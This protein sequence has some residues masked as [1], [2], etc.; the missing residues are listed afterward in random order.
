MELLLTK[1]ADFLLDNLI[2]LGENKGID[3]LAERLSDKALENADDKIREYLISNLPEYEYEQIDRF[4]SKNSIYAHSQAIA[5][6][7]LMSAQTEHLVE[8]FYKN[9]P[10]LQSDRETITPLLNKAFVT[11]YQSVMGQLSTDCKV[12]YSQA[13]ESRIQE[14]AEHEALANRLDDIEKRL[15]QISTKLSYAEVIK[16]FN[17]IAQIIHSGDLSSGESLIELME[18]QIDNRENSYCTALKIFLNG[19][20]GSKDDVDALCIQFIRENP[21][22]S[23]TIRVVTFLLQMEQ[24]SAIKLIADSIIDKKL[25]AV[26]NE[27]ISA[28]LVKCIIDDS[29]R[30][31]QEYENEEYA[32][33]VFANNAKKSGNISD[34]M[35]VYSKIKEQ[36]PSFWVRWS[37]ESCKL[38]LKVT[39]LIVNSNNKLTEM[40]EQVENLLQ[41]ADIFDQLYDDLRMVYINSLLQCVQIL[42][43]AEFRACYNRMGTRTKSMPLAQRY[44]FFSSLSNWKCINEEELKEFCTNTNDD[45]LWA[46]Y[47]LSK[48]MECPNEVLKHIEDNK[49]LLGKEPYAVMAYYEAISIIRGKEIAFETIT[50]LPMP[51]ELAFFYNVYLAELSI[52]QANGKEDIYLDVAV[53]EALSAVYGIPIIQLR[54]LIQLLN[55]AGRWLDASKILE[56][57]QETNPALML[58]RLTILFPHKEQQD[59]CYSLIEKLEPVYNNDPHFMY[60]KGQILEN[61]LSGSGLELFEKAFYCFQTPQYAYYALASR[62]SRNLYVEDEILL[63]ASNSDNVDLLYMCGIIYARNGKTQNSNMKLL[64]GLVNCDDKYHEGLYNAFVT[65][66]LGNDTP[67]STPLKIGI[68]TCCILNNIDTGECIKLWIHDESIKIP[69]QG[70][71]FAGYKHIAPNSNIA[72]SVLE[73][74]LGNIITLSDGKYE[75]AVINTSDVVAVQYCIQRLLEHGVMKTISVDENNLETLFAELRKLNEGRGDHIQNI[76]EKYKAL[77]PG[78]PLELFAI[79]IG[80]SYYKVVFSMVHDAS[81]PF[82]AGIDSKTINSHCIL[83]PS[84]IATL[85]ALNI[86]PPAECVGDMN[87]YVT[88]SLRAE[89][90]LQSRMHR[91]DKTAAVLGFTEEGD[92]YVQENTLESKYYINNYFACLNE[93][94]DWGQILAPV[95]PSDYPLHVKRVAHEVGIPNI[96]ALVH[97]TGNNCIICCDDL[98]LRR[99]LFSGGI[100]TATAIDVMIALNYSYEEIVDAA[101]KLLER[102]YETPI[103]PNFLLWMSNCF[104]DVDDDENNLEQRVLL[105]S[106]LIKKVVGNSEARVYICQAYKELFEER[107]EI[108]PTLKWIIYTA[109]YIERKY[110]SLSQEVD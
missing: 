46:A 16:A 64:Q 34:A 23:L 59:I 50:N 72:F 1:A 42:P 73:Q 19:Y 101:T 76:I 85:S 20:V 98:F 102:N 107:D 94:A 49:L 21:M 17:I 70:S 39:D 31:K 61:E 97:A 100:M 45:N 44:V 4:L 86:H 108:H 38:S 30:L 58:L 41:F 99:Y 89:L 35:E 7:S 57:Y 12:L 28:E 77:D 48:V 43:A 68:E 10:E 106:D 105:A 91:T 60:C 27:Y 95:L 6:W 67:V 24:K 47:L 5:S 65:I 29:G 13:M 71:A 69:S 55:N 78:L 37:V 66:N 84:V 63:Y 56:K 62:I 79:A 40:S 53:N 36:N 88:S 90:N 32:L 3:F 74:K 22:S 8:K 25:F 2:S 54:N 83:T 104:K 87:W 103:T 33:W 92:P 51:K 18:T 26:A 15:S 52:N 110:P 80:E 96:E 11:A 81:I 109:L 14:R 75:V 82:W 9:H 93:W